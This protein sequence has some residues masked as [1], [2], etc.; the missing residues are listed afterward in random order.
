MSQTTMSQPKV[1]VTGG[2]GY[3]GSH[4]VLRL[5]QEGFEP[6]VFGRRAYPELEAQ[7]LRCI[8]GDVRDNEAL[9]AALDGVEVVFHT[10][11]R[12]G[13]WGSYESYAETNIEGTQRL[14]DEAVKAGVKRLIYTSTPSVVVGEEGL[15]PGADETQPFPERYLS[16]YGPTKAEAERRVL[17]ANRPGTFVTGA[18]RPHLIFGPKDTQVVPRLIHHA[19]RGTI[20]RVGDG[21]NLTDVTYIDNAVD[22]HLQLE[23]ALR[24]P[25]SPA[26]GEAFFIGQ[27][28]PVN[29]WD[30]V[31]EVLAGVGAPPV[32]RRISFKAAYRLGWFL[33]GVFQLM[34][35][36][37]EPPMTRMAAVML[38]H[39]HSFSHAKAERMFGYTPRVR[40]EEAMTKTVAY[41]K[42][43]PPA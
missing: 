29:L 40:L 32:S 17:A 15:K 10:A 24:A 1:L 36:D 19:K 43:H 12:V 21:R 34:P 8:R 5:Q 25:D 26:A 18:I 37:K 39:S 6:W 20:A 16:N 38:G 42:A 13:Y 7:G 35:E 31:G 14:L 41:F 30:F 11:A 2:G 4:I 33:E 22:A 23:A 28:R 27:E 3:L 9:K